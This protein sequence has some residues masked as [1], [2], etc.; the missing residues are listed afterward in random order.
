MTDT[1]VVN[2]WRELLSRHASTWCELDRELNER[3]GLGASEFEVLDRLAEGVKDAYRVQ[4]LG[5]MV[6]L[7]QSA[8]SRLI[9]R[10][11]TKGLVV[12]SMCDSDRRGISV[13]LT[14][15]GRE[16]YAAAKPTHRSVLAA[17]FADAPA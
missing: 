8:L 4:E 5:A 12:R 17:S 11:E 2:A 9:G 14:D 16:L 3:Y 1:D 13:C 6:F 15:A 7:S 10:L